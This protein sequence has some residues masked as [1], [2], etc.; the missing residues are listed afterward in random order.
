MG[1]SLSADRLFFFS[2]LAFTVSFLLY[3]G[4]NYL[5]PIPAEGVMD[6]LAN[7][8]S[9]LFMLNQGGWILSTAGVVTF[10]LGLVAQKR[11]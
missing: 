10:V 5:L 2:A 7:P 3:T 1:H 6:P 8:Q 9:L 4:L 11:S